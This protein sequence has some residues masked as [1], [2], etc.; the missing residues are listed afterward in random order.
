MP[1]PGPLRS[2]MEI[3]ADEW[4]AALRLPANETPDVVIVESSWWR[5]QRNEWRL[6]ALAD[7]REL[8]FPDMFWGRWGEKNIV[9][10]CAYGAPRTNEIIH[11]FAILSAKVTLH[12]LLGKI[13]VLPPVGESIRKMSNS[14]PDDY[15]L[16]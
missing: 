8:N 6:S 10:C 5:A 16:V 14:K 12:S 13:W 9:Y 15:R 3:G 7:M 4:R 11:L 1:A 2:I